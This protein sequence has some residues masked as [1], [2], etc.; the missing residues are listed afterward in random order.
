MLVI[1]VIDGRISG[2]LVASISLMVGCWAVG[3][4]GVG[5]SS[6]GAGWAYSSFLIVSRLSDRS[7]GSF[8]TS[9]PSKGNTCAMLSGVIFR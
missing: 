1:C 9:S 4:G 3:C 6:S 2:V 8:L 7:A 5:N